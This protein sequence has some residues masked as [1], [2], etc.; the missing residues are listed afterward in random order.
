MTGLLAALF[1]DP[2]TFT[3]GCSTPDTVVDAVDQGVLEALFFDGAIRADGAG[4]LDPYTVAREESRR[5]VEPAVAVD[6][7]FGVHW[8]NLRRHECSTKLST[9]WFRKTR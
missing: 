1:E 5:R 8:E 6:H 3:L 2:S 9:V 4:D 7:P